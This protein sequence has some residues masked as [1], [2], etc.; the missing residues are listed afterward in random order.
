V[1][2]PA[3]RCFRHD[4]RRRPRDVLPGAD[5]RGPG[6]GAEVGSNLAERN[7]LS[8]VA[9]TYGLVWLDFG[10]WGRCSGGPYL[11]SK[12][13]LGDGQRTGGFAGCEFEII[14]DVFGVEADWDA[15]A[16]ALGAL[17]VGPRVHLGECCAL[18]A[19]AQIPN[20][21]G[22]SSFRALAQLEVTYP[23]KQE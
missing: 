15:G 9:R 3:A 20:A 5:W 17:S 7:E 21:W 11:A 8:L 19:G 16:H 10:E 2:L 13:L 6:A 4:S 12:T 14:P 1:V 23:G 22:S 18:S